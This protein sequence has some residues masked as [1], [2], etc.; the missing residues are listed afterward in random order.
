ML[1]IIEITEDQV[2]FV[3]ELFEKAKILWT[4]HNFEQ[5]KFL[6]QNAKDYSIKNSLVK[7]IT[8]ADQLIRNL[9]EDF[10][11]IQKNLLSNKKKIHHFI[12]EEKLNRCP[13]HEEINANCMK[14]KSIRRFIEKPKIY[15]FFMYEFPNDNDHEYFMEIIKIKELIEIVNKDPLI[16]IKFPSYSTGLDIK[17]CDFCKFARS[18]DF[19]ILLLTPANPNAYLEA[20]MFIS[21]G[22]KVVLLN[23]EL[24]SK[25]A[26]FDLTPYFYIPY[27]N[28]EELEENWNK[29]LPKYLQNIKDFYLSPQ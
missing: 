21:L 29:K 25:Y 19:G 24:R 11:I 16:K 15:G 20:G 28:L 2:I 27:Q 9:N 3:S 4:Q 6:I 14:I 5:A 23:N 22:K 1:K 17:T 13:L 10:Y 12:Y 8:R 7:S 26:P 18:F